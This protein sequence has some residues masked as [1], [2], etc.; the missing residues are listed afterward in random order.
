MFSGSIVIEYV[1]APFSMRVVHRPFIILVPSDFCRLVDG[2]R[3]I[4]T[5]W[6]AYFSLLFDVIAEEGLRELV[7]FFILRA[8]LVWEL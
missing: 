5:Y 8:E 6:T 4:E 3:Y 2:R 7:L 1:I